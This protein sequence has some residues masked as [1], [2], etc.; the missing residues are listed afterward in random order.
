[1]TRQLTSHRNSLKQKC[2]QQ[3]EGIASLEH[4]TS[5][6][7]LIQTVTWLEWMHTRTWMC[8]LT[9]AATQRHTY[10]QYNL[11]KTIP[12]V[13]E[14]T[15]GKMKETERSRLGCVG[16]C[17]AWK[18]NSFEWKGGELNTPL[19]KQ[20]TQT[21]QLLYLY[22]K[23]SNFPLTFLLLCF[24]LCFSWRYSHIVCI[25]VLWQ[26]CPSAQYLQ[27]MFV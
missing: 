21:S 16:T 3:P 10:R 6:M 14:P 13:F 18:L 27:D 9:N 4:L 26:M 19:V 5:W 12:P 24:Y 1:M 22:D 23:L 15:L 7:F 8:W 2:L 25:D 20:Q 17:V 11:G